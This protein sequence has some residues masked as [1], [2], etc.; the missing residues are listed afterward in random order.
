MPIY[1]CSFPE[2]RKML[3]TYFLELLP[4][5][6]TDLLQTLH[7][8]SVDSPDRNLFKDIPNNT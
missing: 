1:Y 5:D 6:F 7:T 8:A 3:Q 4:G 2:I